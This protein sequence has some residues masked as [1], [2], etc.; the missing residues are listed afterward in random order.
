[1]SVGNSGRIVIE[2]DP[3]LKRQL[4]VFLAEQGLTLKDWFVLNARSSIDEQKISG[5]SLVNMR[6]ETSPQK[7]K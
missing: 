2:V 5:K 7:W 1:M 4:Y 6:D 3:A